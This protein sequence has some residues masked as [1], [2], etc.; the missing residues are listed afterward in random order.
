MRT[1]TDVQS[2]YRFTCSALFYSAR[3]DSLLT[4]IMRSPLQAKTG[5]CVF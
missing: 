5:G 1:A 3:F 4:V 2:T